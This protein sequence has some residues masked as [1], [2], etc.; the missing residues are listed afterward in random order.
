MLPLRLGAPAGDRLRVLLLGAHADDVE[1]GCG[2]TLLQ[3]AER[4]PDLRAHTVV[5]SAT[6]AR[7]EE[8]RE[9][10]AAFGPDGRTTVE[11]HD[12]ADGRLPAQWAA[13]KELLEDVAAREPADLV[14]A[15][16]TADAHQDHRTLAEVVASVWRDHLVLGYEIP[17][18]DRDLGRPVLHVPLDDATMTRK[19]A[20]LRRCFPS[21]AGRA[22]FDDEVFRGLARLR[23]V[24]CR[25]TY[26]EAF[27][28][29]TL[30]LR[31]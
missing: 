8:A 3:L 15:P 6:P 22:W 9:S 12:L 30:A 23:G 21:Q 26:A 25:A 17:K 10:A 28:P 5:L 16:T 4:R 18:Y 13:V 24:E 1:I 31:L 7:A 14:L 2:G 29:A 11:V 27:T 20:L 19:C